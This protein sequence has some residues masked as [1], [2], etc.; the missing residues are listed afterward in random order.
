MFIQIFIFIHINYYYC[1]RIRDLKRKWNRAC[2]KKTC[3][4]FTQVY[5]MWCRS[6]VSQFALMTNSYTH[7]IE[8]RLHISLSVASHFLP[9][10]ML[11]LYAHTFSEKSWAVNLRHF[12]DRKLAHPNAWPTKGCNIAHGFNGFW[13]IGQWTRNVCLYKWNQ[14]HLQALQQFKI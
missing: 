5:S 1:Q 6:T 8:Y 14:G 12:M 7:T 13:C 11:V 4:L 10:N 9:D 2:Y 3:C